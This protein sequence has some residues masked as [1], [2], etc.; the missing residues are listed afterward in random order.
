MKKK[1]LFIGITM[2]CAGTEKSF[3]SFI[4]TFDFDKYDATLLLAKKKGPFLKLLPNKLKIIEI[5][6]YGDHFLQSG[7]NARGNIYNTF[8]RKNPFTAFTVLPYY[9]KIMLH[10][11]NVSS[12]ATRLWI[13]L[14]DYLP[15]IDEKF[16]VAVAYWGD[17]T[18]FYMLDK[19]K[20][21][22]YITWMHFDYAHPKRDDSI[23]LPYFKR[24][25]SIVNVSSTVDDALKKSLPEL[26]GKCVVIENINS[27]SA[28]K[29]MADEPAI[30]PDPDYQ[31]KR[32]LSVGRITFQK[33]FDLAIRALKHLRTDGIDA[34]W[35]VIGE[36][37]NE[38]KKNLSLLAEE[39]GVAD[40][41]VFMGAYPN[42]Y[43]FIKKCDVYAQPSRFEG[44]PI[45][46]E[47]AK[48]LSK[49]IVVCD[50][51]SAAEQ[52]RSGKL[53]LISSF[54]ETDLSEKLEM[55][56]TDDALSDSLVKSLQSEM[57]SNEAE[58]SKFYNLI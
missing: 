22:K 40:S 28:I 20:A 52:L 44:K 47:E 5:N 57:L 30:F 43:P 23:Y 1:I 7:K 11:E 53:G 27:P 33:G 9:I 32:I 37:D 39:Y 12:D 38:Y 19:V 15:A 16:D 3:V 42:P 58:I 6:N 35:Y 36:G 45:S 54:E 34:K 4:N 48:I 14:M 13:R 8:I 55:L 51:L 29:I 24:C 25:D 31:G 21:D 10:P 17:R 26:S 41:F 56:L 18:M 50:Y 49:P 46:V 2:N